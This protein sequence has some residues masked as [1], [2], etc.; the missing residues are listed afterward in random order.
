MIRWGKP[1]PAPQ[2]PT[3][4][5]RNKRQALERGVVY[6]LVSFPLGYSIGRIIKHVAHRGQA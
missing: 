1:T 3:R 4:A 5:A 6:V 2:P